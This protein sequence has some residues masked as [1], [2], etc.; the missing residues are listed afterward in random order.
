MLFL[1][2][3]CKL[4]HKLADMILHKDTTCIYII[5]TSL[6][7]ISYSY[8]IHECLHKIIYLDS[9]MFWFLHFEHT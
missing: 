9:T 2:L 1:M 5:Q 8:V 3:C 4:L 6:F 7:D